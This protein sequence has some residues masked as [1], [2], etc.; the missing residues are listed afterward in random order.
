M[1]VR[2]DGVAGRPNVCFEKPNERSA[3]EPGMETA[4]VQQSTSTSDAWTS[5]LKPLPTRSPEEPIFRGKSPVPSRCH[6]TQQLQPQTL[7]VTLNCQP[8]L[9]ASSGRN[10]AEPP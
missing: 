5:T 6:A 3:S 4:S 7:R 8:L 10:R 1:P 2:G 9:N